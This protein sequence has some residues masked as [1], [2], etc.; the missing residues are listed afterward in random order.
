M[1]QSVWLEAVSSCLVLT[2]EVFHAIPKD[3]LGKKAKWVKELPV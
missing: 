3:S 2:E 1:L